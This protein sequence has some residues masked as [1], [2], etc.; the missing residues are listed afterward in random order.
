MKIVW[1]VGGIVIGVVLLWIIGVYLFDFIARYID[2]KHPSKLTP[3][4][5]RAADYAAYKAKQ[6]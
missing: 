4:E 2:R 5:Q 6:M 1:I 3:D